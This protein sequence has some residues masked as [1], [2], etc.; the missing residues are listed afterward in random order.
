MDMHASMTESSRHAACKEAGM[1]AT[2]TCRQPD[3]TA[4]AARK[5]VEDHAGDLA[6]L[7]HASAIPDEESS[8]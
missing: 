5:V 6:A 1:V 2:R 3:G 4:A 8:A 7:A